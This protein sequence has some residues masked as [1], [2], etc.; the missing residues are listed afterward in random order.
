MILFILSLV[1]GVLLIYL[2]SPPESA[3]RIAHRAETE[4]ALLSSI[5]SL[6]S[7]DTTERSAPKPKIDTRAQLLGFLKHAGF[8]RDHSAVNN[9]TSWYRYADGA[10]TSGLLAQF[11]KGEN[12]F[13]FYF[14]GEYSSGDHFLMHAGKVETVPEFMP[15][16]QNLCEV[17]LTSGGDF[18][19]GA[20]LVLRRFKKFAIGS[21]LPGAAEV[22]SEKISN[23]SKSDAEH[24]HRVLKSHEELMRSLG[25]GFTVSKTIPKSATI[26]ET[27]EALGVE[28]IEDA[29]KSMGLAPPLYLRNPANPNAHIALKKTST[30][31]PPLL[32]KEAER[33]WQKKQTGEIGEEQFWREYDALVEFNKNNK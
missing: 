11:T 8:K 25:F 30:P 21:K 27:R 24:M 12:G 20:K 19:Y 23:S 32:S 33:L 15:L 29:F 14:E 1:A 4:A 3:E 28:R 9:K 17:V 5:E 7:S 18:D 16:F 10:T 2:L 26:N 31:T 22:L 13:E 6:F